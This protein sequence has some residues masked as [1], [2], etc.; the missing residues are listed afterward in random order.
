MADNPKLFRVILEVAD[1]NAAVEFYYKLFGIEGRVLRGSRAYFDCGPVILAI[2]DPTPGDVKPT[3]NVGDVYFS[4]KDIEKVHARARELGW[5]SKEEVHDESAGD[6]VTRPWGERSF[7]V[8]D[9]WGNGLCFVDEKTLY[10]G[11]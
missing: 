7:Y 2:L 3:P 1:L 9:P 10:T 5:L 6:I 8:K 4:V 11:R